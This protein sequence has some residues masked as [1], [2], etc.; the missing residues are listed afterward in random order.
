MLLLAPVPGTTK[1][2]FE[3]LSG[4]DD[5]PTNDTNTANY[6]T[7]GIPTKKNLLSKIAIP[8]EGVLKFRP[9]YPSCTAGTALLT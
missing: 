4:D 2:Y 7:A 3:C 5:G 8:G 6:S 9:G 1:N